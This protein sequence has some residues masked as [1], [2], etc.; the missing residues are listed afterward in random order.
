[1]DRRWLKGEIWEV[2]A[3]RFVGEGKEAIGTLERGEGAADA[4][5][6][7]EW[8]RVASGNGQTGDGCSSA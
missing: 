2:K 7:R 3:K 5:R 4:E 1:M 6:K 8:L